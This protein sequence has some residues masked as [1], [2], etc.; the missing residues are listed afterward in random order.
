MSRQREILRLLKESREK[1]KNSVKESFLEALKESRRRKVSAPGKQVEAEI[2][3]LL[4]VLNVAD[5]VELR[6]VQL[7]ELRVDYEPKRGID[8]LVSKIRESGKVLPLLVA[9][10]IVQEGEHRYQ[11]LKRL[12]VRKVP[13]LEI[14]TGALFDDEDALLEVVDMYNLSSD[15]LKIEVGQKITESSQNLDAEYLAAVEAGDT[16]KQKAMV[17]SAAGAVGYKIGPVYH[18]TV[19]EEFD[20]FDPSKVG[21]T[22]YPDTQVGTAFFFTNDK[23]TAACVASKGSIAAQKPRFMEVFLQLQNPIEYDPNQWGEPDVINT[24]RMAR[25]IKMAQ[26]QGRD[27]VVYKSK[28]MGTTYVV[29]LPEQIKL[30]DPITYDD[31]GDVIPL[32]RRFNASSKKIT[33]SSQTPETRRELEFV[34]VNSEFEGATPLEKQDELFDRLKKV[35]GVIVYVQDFSEGEET[36]KSMAAIVKDGREKTFQKIREIAANV[37]VELDLENEVEEGFIDDIV[38]NRL[39]ALDKWYD[40]DAEQGV[41]EGSERKS[42]CEVKWYNVDK[43]DMKKEIMRMVRLLKKMY[44][45]AGYS[46]SNLSRS[47][48]SDSVYFRVEGLG[49]YGTEIRVSDHAYPGQGTFRGWDIN[50]D[51]D[52]ESLQEIL[53]EMQEEI[54]DDVEEMAKYKKVNE[55]FQK[56]GVFFHGTRKDFDVLKKN[57]SHGVLWLTEE[58]EKAVE[59]SQPYYHKG[60]S[61]LWKVQLSLDTEMVDL[62]D[63]SDPVI[64]DLIEEMNKDKRNF[65]PWTKERWEKEANFGFIEVFQWITSF[66]RRKGIDAVVVQDSVGSNALNTHTSIA[67]L[68]MKKIN[69]AEKIVLERNVAEAVKYFESAEGKKLDEEIGSQEIEI[70]PTEKQKKSGNYRKG[71]IKLHGLNI[72]IENPKGSFRS[73]KAKDGKEWSQKLKHH[74]GY[75]K[76]TVGRDKDH[77]DVFIGNDP[78]S[79]KVFVINQLDQDGKF[80]EHKCMV[81]FK[82]EE[83]ARKGYLANYEKGWQGL[84]SVVEKSVDEFRD[85]LKNGNTRRELKESNG[86]WKGEVL[87]HSSDDVFDDGKPDFDAYFGTQDWKDV[88]RKE[89]GDNEYEIVLLDSERE[90]ILDLESGSKDAVFIRTLWGGVIEDGDDFYSEDWVDKEKILPEVKKL[91]YEGVKFQDEYILSEKLIKR[92]PVKESKGKVVL[93]EGAEYKKVIE[94]GEK[95]VKAVADKMEDVSNWRNLGWDRF[96]F[97]TP[98]GVYVL[99]RDSEEF[100]AWSAFAPDRSEIKVNSSGVPA[101]VDALDAAVEHFWNNFVYSESFKES[102]FK[103]VLGME[104]RLVC[105]SPGSVLVKTKKKLGE[106]KSPFEVIEKVV[107]VEEGSFVLVKKEEE[108]SV[109]GPLVSVRKGTSAERLGRAAVRAALGQADQDN[110]VEKEVVVEKA[111]IL[112]RGTKDKASAISKRRDKEKDSWKKYDSLNQKELLKMMEEK[113]GSPLPDE[114][115][116]NIGLMKKKEIREKAIWEWKEEEENEP[117]GDEQND[118]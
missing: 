83:A 91:G 54:D 32:S 69:G 55:S 12:G 10:M 65:A 105:V 67:L 114:I 46:C 33:E 50:L 14:Q 97:D 6:W 51:N 101:Q 112:R 115:K 3:Q 81:G 104:K 117:R 1:K 60:N 47:P 61:F 23:L 2:N 9:D 80:D 41:K 26:E 94:A 87:Y 40:T 100:D 99:K 53:E 18:G 25:M 82:N 72:S 37:G 107:K 29:L 52:Q 22:G 70:E 106:D 118:S 111:Y 48:F 17:K 24:D 92:L 21:R 5:S 43:P 85:W 7:E 74:Y 93:M 116:K 90:N 16:E 89:F 28:A 103:E 77:V 38:A 8:T 86:G 109:R 108:K 13:I 78:E 49:R 30:A 62:L 42:L 57:K 68:N 4:K 98:E 36:Q 44:R 56:G 27:G 110:E 88:F 64:V 34:C 95:A 45:S 31:N 58:R 20:E 113:Y 63:T 73:G 76:G 71:K 39:E 66:F 102:V 75:I 19:F 96:E 84:G 35:P 15:F 79:E 11:A 59:Y